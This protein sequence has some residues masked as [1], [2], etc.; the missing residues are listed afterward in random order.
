MSLRREVVNLYKQ[1]LWIGRD[2][3]AGYDVFRNGLKRA[4]LKMKDEKD[5]T[6]IR[7]AISRGEYVFKEVE[8]L[9]KLHKYRALKRSYYRPDL[10]FIPGY[11]NEEAF[12]ADLS[13]QS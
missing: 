11:T 7:E 12:L 8:A 13:K 10:A 5:P 6:K 9:L 3:P 2:Y 4:F 1:L